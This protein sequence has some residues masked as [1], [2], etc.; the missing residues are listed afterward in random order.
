M[1]G[2]HLPT[3]GEWTDS[4]SAAHE[5]PPSSFSHEEPVMKSLALFFVLCAMQLGC[6]QTP[7]RPVSSKA[8][9]VPPKKTGVASGSFARDE[10]SASQPVP[11][12]ETR[13][14]DS[15]SVYPEKNEVLAILY[16]ARELR[17]KSQFQSALE[18]VSQAR[19]VDPHSP[20]AQIMEREIAEILKR[21]GAPENQQR[22][23]S[24]SRAA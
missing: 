10:I 2:I 7:D 1:T 23:G 5:N 14:S 6:S 17:Q 8:K 24:A 11:P 16:R 4:M 22:T 18:L 20:A 21:L 13:P 9:T 3:G 15:G 12:P 19:V